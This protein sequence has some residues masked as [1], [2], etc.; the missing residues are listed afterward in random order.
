VL[1]GPSIWATFPLEF[2]HSQ[3]SPP[4]GTLRVRFVSLSLR[5]RSA[6]TAMSQAAG[7]QPITALVDYERTYIT[8]VLTLQ[9]INYLT[10][11]KQKI[12]LISSYNQLSLNKVVTSRSRRFC[13]YRL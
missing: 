13:R 6:I 11:S 8:N 12:F 4:N 2:P 7:C 10:G 5:N 9:T 1:G 3:N